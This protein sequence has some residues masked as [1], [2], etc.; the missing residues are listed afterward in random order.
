[1]IFRSKSP[2][3]IARL[4]QTPRKRPECTTRCGRGAAAGAQNRLVVV[5]RVLDARAW[6][7]GWRVGDVVVGVKKLA[8]SALD[9]E[10]DQ[11]ARQAGAAVA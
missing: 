11:H 7:S 5:K 9:A 2:P 6:D 4:E 1:M 3:P 8:A 10:F